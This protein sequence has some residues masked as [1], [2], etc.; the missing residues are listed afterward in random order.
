M[1]PFAAWN[2]FGKAVMAQ[3]KDFPDPVASQQDSDCWRRFSFPLHM[4]QAHWRVFHQ[5]MRS[6]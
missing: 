6:Y 3:R 5:R 2:K 1:S 4:R